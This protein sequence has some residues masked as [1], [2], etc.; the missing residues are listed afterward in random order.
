MLKLYLNLYKKYMNIENLTYLFE[1]NKYQ[2]Y[3][4][5]EIGFS[6]KDIGWQHS[7]YENFGEDM[8]STYEMI[9]N[10]YEYSTN[11]ISQIWILKDNIPIGLC[12]AIHYKEHDFIKYKDTGLTC[13]VLGH[14]HLFIKPEHRRLGLASM[15]VP[16]LEQE[17]LK[18]NISYP[19]AI[20]L[21]GKAY[22][23]NA[24][25][26]DSLALPYG[27]ENPHYF[28]ENPKFL[29]SAFKQIFRKQYN[30]TMMCDKYPLFQKDI[31]N[32]HTAEYFIKRAITPIIY[33]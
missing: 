24:Y 11:K 22:H 30:L 3:S 6:R 23:S 16:L 15:A 27:Q 7:L 18:E 1:H 2:F 26:K 17:L 10:G 33:I 29:C 12:I 32:M 25:L 19:P 21:E 9:F 13:E 8:I 28:H 4:T 14:I 31:K 5:T 20:I